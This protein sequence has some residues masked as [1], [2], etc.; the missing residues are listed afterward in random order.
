MVE[1]NKECCK[2]SKAMSVIV[3][4]LLGAALIFIGVSLGIRWL[5]PLKILVKAC[6]GPF[7]I[8]VGLVFIAIAKE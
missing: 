1:E 3:K 8:L 4:M 2:S 6:L 7:I 5:E